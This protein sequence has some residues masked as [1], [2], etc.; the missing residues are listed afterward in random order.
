MIDA[1]K[2]LSFSLTCVVVDSLIK[3]ELINTDAIFLELGPKLCLWAT[4][5]LFAL[6][7]ADRKL[8]IAQIVNQLRTMR[9]ELNTD[10][11]IELINKID[12]QPR[13]HLLFG[14]SLSAWVVCVVLSSKSILLFNAQGIWSSEVLF[15]FC[16]SLTIGVAAMISAVCSAK[17]VSKQ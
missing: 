10:Q 5:T 7:L 1:I 11:I 17:G 12:P 15:R 6:C 16:A 9:G 2:I 8:V 14:I 4:S 13:F 3:W